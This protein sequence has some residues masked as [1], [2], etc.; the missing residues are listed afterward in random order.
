MVKKT[1][2][3]CNYLRSVKGNQ[4][5][6]EETICFFLGGRNTSKILLKVFKVAHKN[7]KRENL[8][9]TLVIQTQW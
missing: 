7:Q 1:V 9:A 2:K 6:S 8:K 4:D 5:F 3:Y